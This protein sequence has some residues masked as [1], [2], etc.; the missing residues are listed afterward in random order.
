[1]LCNVAADFLSRLQS[2]PNETIEIKLRER[3]PIREIENDVGAK[4]P[5]YTI[6]ELFAEDLPLDLL[7]VVDINT[8]L[9][10]K[11]LQ[12]LGYSSR[13]QCQTSSEGN[14]RTKLRQQQCKTCGQ[15]QVAKWYPSSSAQV[16]TGPEMP[17]MRSVQHFQKV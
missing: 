2:N 15:L 13:T 10:L 9:K 14:Y 6:S 8:F 3:I 1:M 11:Q 7:Q 12:K 17:S 4:L 16:T 5:N